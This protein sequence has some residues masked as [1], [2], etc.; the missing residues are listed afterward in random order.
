MPLQVKCPTCG[1]TLVLEH[2]FQGARCLC[3][4]CRS[5]VEVE[6][7]PSVTDRAAIRPE[8][9][10]L[11]SARVAASKAGVTAGSSRFASTRN[12]I[13]AR[14]SV[15][16][17]AATTSILLAVMLG[18]V[19]WTS[20]GSRRDDLESTSPQRFAALDSE[21][22]GVASTLPILA[23]NNPRRAIQE[24]DPFR[25]YFGIPLNGE[26]VGYIVDSDAT[27]APYIDRVAMVTNSIISRFPMESIRFGVVQPSDESSEVRLQEVYQAAV[28]QLE[29][30]TP[31]RART[32]S[33]TTSLAKAFAVTEAW[34]PEELFLVLSKPVSSQEVDALAQ[35]AKQSGAVTHVIALG[36]AAD[37][38]GLSR[39]AEATAG[40]YVRISDDDLNLLVSRHELATPVTSSPAESSAP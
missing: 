26:T 16:R 7:R 32:A 24:N 8:R 5:L 34:Y 19:M 38:P 11:E 3:K 18:V 20:S 23:S 13:A 30:R 28:L 35:L 21:S 22:E 15:Y 2:V 1:R 12:W 37:E 40:Q 17:V 36:A 33:G 4:H 9:P 39:I 10:P 25:S 27:M 14:V 31:L 6:R 29:G